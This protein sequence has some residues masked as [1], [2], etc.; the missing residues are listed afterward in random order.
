M[1][2]TLVLYLSSMDCILLWRKSDFWTENSGFVV[3]RDLETA[4]SYGWI[5][6][7]EL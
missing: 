6:I 5:V 7:G 2:S 4:I 3:W 1:K